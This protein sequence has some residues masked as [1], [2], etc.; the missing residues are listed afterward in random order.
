M[1]DFTGHRVA[2]LAAKFHTFN[3]TITFVGGTQWITQPNPSKQT[4]SVVFSVLTEESKKSYLQDRVKVGGITATVEVLR[5]FSAT[6]QCNRCQGFAHNPLKCRAR[7]R[8]RLCGETHFT[9]DHRCLIYEASGPC[10]HVTPT[11]ANCKE[12]H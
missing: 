6:T 2:N 12:S 5:S 7:P 3:P 4:G 8:C 10:Q 11:Y 9:K 1:R